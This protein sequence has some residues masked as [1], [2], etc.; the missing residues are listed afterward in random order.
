MTKRA[1]RGD[2]RATE[3]DKRVGDIRATE[4]DIIRDKM[5]DWGQQKWRRLVTHKFHRNKVDRKL[6]W[7][8]TLISQTEVD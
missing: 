6:Q 1:T 7:R 3:G 4:G 5:G 2:K 8:G